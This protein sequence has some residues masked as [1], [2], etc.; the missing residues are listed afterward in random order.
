M[1]G[2]GKTTVGRLLA[3]VIPQLFNGQTYATVMQG[4]VNQYGRPESYILATF[5]K[6]L[7]VLQYAETI[8]SVQAVTDAEVRHLASYENE[9]MNAECVQ[10]KAAY[11]ADKSVTPSEAELTAQFNRYKSVLPGD[12]N[13][14]NPYGFGYKLPDR[15]Q[16]EYIAVK[17]ADVSSIVPTP[18]QEE[19]ETFYRDNRTRL[20]TE[21]VQTCLL[22]TS[23]AADALL[24]VD[25]GGR[26]II[27]KK[28]QN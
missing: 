14:I 21:Q 26:R 12:A 3:Q 6:V 10:M 13:E 15:L 7:A 16:L 28:T 4:M 18:A 17:L 20:F 5:G 25:L 22:Y 24:C 11:F 23:D 1:M 2:A 9:T 8:C 27:T 19:I